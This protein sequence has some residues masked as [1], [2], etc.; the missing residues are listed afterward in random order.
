MEGKCKNCFSCIF[1]LYI[2]KVFSCWGKVVLE[3]A[4]LTHFSFMRKLFKSFLWRE[5]SRPRSG[6][7][8]SGGIKSLEN[9]PILSKVNK[10]KVYA[11]HFLLWCF[12]A[13][14]R[15]GLIAI[16]RKFQRQLALLSRNFFFKSNVWKCFWQIFF[17]HI[18]QPGWLSMETM[19]TFKRL[20]KICSDEA[21]ILNAL[22]KSK[23]GLMEVDRL[24]R[25]IRRD[26]SVRIYNS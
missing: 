13:Q 23:T 3:P 26:P 16:F 25:R 17:P 1:S 10:Y 2:Y 22:L 12:W 24:N 19:L 6:F 14:F 15:K 20:S 4:L 5:G 8:L 7:D 21:I 18:F 11:L 9:L